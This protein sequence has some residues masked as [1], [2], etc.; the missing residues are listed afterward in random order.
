[1]SLKLKLNSSIQ[2]SQENTENGIHGDITTE[3]TL[4]RMRIST[5][6]TVRHGQFLCESV[7]IYNINTEFLLLPHSSLPSPN[8][9]KI[10]PFFF[11][12]FF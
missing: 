1:M 7:L 2:E 10:H 6:T 8:P 12:S 4:V 3:D 9:L 5:G 11:S